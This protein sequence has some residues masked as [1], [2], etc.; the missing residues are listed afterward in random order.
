MA[1]NAKFTLYESGLLRGFCQAERG[2]VGTALWS[3]VCPPHPRFETPTL[4]PDPLPRD[5]HTDLE[6]GARPFAES[7]CTYLPLKYIF[8]DQLQLASPVQ[9]ELGGLARFEIGRLDINGMLNTESDTSLELRVLLQSVSL[10]DIRQ[11]STLAV[12]R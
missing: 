11:H 4:T 1:E 10:D 9:D 7:A 5:P 6:G 12:K 3:H 2:D 8:C